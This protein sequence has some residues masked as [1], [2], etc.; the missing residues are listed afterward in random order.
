[1]SRLTA[2]A[3]LAMF[4]FAT[5]AQAQSHAANPLVGTW[6]VAEIA[7]AN[8]PPLSAPQPGLYI[9]TQQ[10]YSMLRING[11]K[12]L[13]D[14]PSNDKATDAEKVAVFNAIFGNVVVMV[15]SMITGATR[16]GWRISG[17]SL[18]NPVYWCLHSFASWRALFQVFFNPFAWEKTPHG[19]VQG[20]AEQG[21]VT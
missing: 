19:L 7:D 13:P 2:V 18:L 8:R 21:V 6:R 15:L 20:K 16:H 4:A 11:A 1:M 3:L 12:P 10:H 9:F 5:A 17:Y 14:Y